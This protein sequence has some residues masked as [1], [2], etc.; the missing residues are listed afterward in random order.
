MSEFRTR[1]WIAR[2]VV[3]L[4]ALLFAVPFVS[5]QVTTGNLQGIVRDQNDAVVAGASVKVTNTA[6]GASRE[7]TTNEEG[8]YRV[9]NLLP[10]DTYMIEV[11]AA[12]FQPTKVEQIA[13]R[14]G[15]ENSGDVKLGVTQVTGGT[16]QV[17]GETPLIQSTQSQLS[18]AYTPKQLTQLPFNGSIDNLA[19]L[20]PGVVTPGD[21][22]FTNGVGI[23]ANGNRARSNNFQIDGQDNNDNSV[24]GPTLSLTNAEAIGEYQIIT[25]SFS[26]EFGRNSGAQVNV[27]TR[28][29]TNEFHGALF[30]FHQNAALNAR[31]NIEKRSQKS[32]DF[33]A[34]SGFTQFAPFARRLEGA[35]PFLENRFGGRLGGPIKENKAFFFATYEGTF[36]RGEAYSENLTQGL[37]HLEAGSAAF[38]AARF[39][40]PFIGSTA[41]SGQPSLV[42]GQGTFLIA[43]PVYDSNGDGVA[44]G[45]AFAAGNPFGN[46]VTANLLAPLAV[47]S[48]TPGGAGRTVIYG[49]EGVRNVR[50]EQT[51]HQ[52]IGRVDWNVTDK[53]T[54]IGRYIFDDS[55]FPL[56]TGRFLQ[57]ALFDVPSRNNNF[58]VTYTRIMSPNSTN[59]ARFNFSRLFVTF[60]DT[61]VR[62]QP[63]IGIQGNTPFADYGNQFNSFATYGTLNT[64]PQSRQVDVYQ[65]QDTFSTTWGNHALKF[66]ADIRQQKVQNFFLPNFLGVYAFRGTPGNGLPGAPR[67]DGFF[68]FGTNGLNGTPR[69]ATGVAGP[70]ENYLLGRPARVTFAAGDPAVNTNQND[71]FFFVQDDWRIRPT[72]TLNLGLRYE[73]STQPFNPIIDDVN[74]REASASTSLFPAGF[75]LSS[76]T[77]NHVPID[78]NNFA[79]RFG[80]AWSPN[81][82]FLGD[83]FSNGRTV[84]RGG[85]G[86][87]YDPSYFN[88]VLNTVT[89]APYA[90]A[91]TI[92]Q[93]PGA[94]GSF[95]VG[96]LP[97]TPAQLALTPGTNGGDPRLFNQTRV[98]DDFR[99]PYTM[100]FNF[101]IQQELH[102]NGVIEARYV[103]SRIVG[104]FQTINAN[105]DLRLLALAAAQLFETAPGAAN[106]NPTRFTH[107]V[108]IPSFPGQPAP[109]AANGF[110]S[111]PVD[112]NGG[113]ITGSGRIDPNF[114]PVRTRLNGASSTYHGLQ[115][116]YDTRLANSLTLNANYSLSKT[117]DNASEIFSTF[118]GGQSIATSQDPFDYN[119]GERGLSAFHQ[120]HTFT[121]NFLYELPWYKEQRGWTGKLLGGYQINGIVRLGSGRP[122]TPV[123][124]FGNIDLGFESG[125][126]S[127]IGPT[128]PFNGNPNAPIGTIAFGY[129]AACDVLFG[130]PACA[131][132]VPGNFIIYNTL[133]P[134]STGTVVA[135]AAAAAQ[136]SRL[137]YN[138]F[139]MFTNF[140]AALGGL[141]AN[142]FEALSYFK[143]PYGDVGRNTF[144]GEP[145]YTLNMSVFKTTKITENVSVEFRAEGFNL[146]NRRNFGVPD[147]FTEDAFLGFTVGSFQNAGFN[148]GGSRTMRLGVRLIF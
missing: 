67:G 20:T 12:G 145:F 13:V 50:S 1:N 84:I 134:G 24:A 129:H 18:T 111:R 76:R 132:A 131:T 17:T 3:L 70:T 61:D 121:A 65:Y 62:Y 34:R 142:D 83:R 99:N 147:T 66:G 102:A 109:S 37:Y 6:T 45:F 79:P 130:G 125:F 146:F 119:D 31:D 139:G 28:S 100:S 41:A 95:G 32:F 47:V 110:N 30:E 135:N 36:F 43:P 16:I 144:S 48:T 123:Q 85:F 141:T 101:G 86:I 97:S 127:A 124:A 33:L 26:A 69:A 8:F 7:A 74:A 60:G 68:N 53:D 25:N 35:Y 15:V 22:D 54:I 58:G 77:L 57:G 10:G 116:R 133:S 81:I 56:V 4:V 98:A 143:S 46:P 44:D 140:A 128:R 21:A 148:N 55:E 122:Y 114:G 73:I 2:S 27:V 78:K 104:Q 75:P 80:F 136:Q 107:G 51:T 103:G 71:F 138:D 137:I 40:N 94:P 19:L 23:S 108:A 120:K 11:T 87:S 72:L 82:K 105:P 59:E 92:F 112:A 14:L 115:I 118:G 49:G 38:A 96:Q 89:A 42:Q 93:T 63:Q 91:G 5:A 29:G 64:F 106:G 90:A 9:T 39:N 126:L 52:L 113:R 88:I 117:I